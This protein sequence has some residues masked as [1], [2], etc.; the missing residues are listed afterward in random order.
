MTAFDQLKALKEQ[1]M[2][3]VDVEKAIRSRERTCEEAIGKAEAELNAIRVVR[4]YV[5]IQME[6]LSNKIAKL[7]QEH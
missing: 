3:L 1:R 4:G 2:G 5:R 7:E 6:E